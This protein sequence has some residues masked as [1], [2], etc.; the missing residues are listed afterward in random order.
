MS[1]S[2]TDKLKAAQA[3]FRE[4]AAQQEKVQEEFWD[5]LTPDQ[6]IDVFCCVVRRI[7][8]GD[9]ELQGSYR[10]VL[11]DVFGFGMEAYVPAQCAGYLELH[12]LIADGLEYR[13]KYRN[14]D[15][16]EEVNALEAAVDKINPE[17][18]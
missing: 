16:T 5:E 2:F 1:D 17:K 14:A 7:Y 10:Y 15:L 13:E 6:Q 8:R 4:V 9:V 3:A 12:N 18:T 11:Y